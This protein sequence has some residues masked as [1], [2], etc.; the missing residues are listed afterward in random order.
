MSTKFRENGQRSRQSLNLIPT[1]FN[2][3]KVWIFW[4][5]FL[6]CKSIHAIKGAIPE[7]EK[8]QAKLTCESNPSE[9]YE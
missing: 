5:M 8:K 3:F 4:K 7:I 6:N 9:K 1:K 2:T